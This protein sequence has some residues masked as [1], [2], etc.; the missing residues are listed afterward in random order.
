MKIVFNLADKDYNGF[1]S[2]NELKDV[3]TRPEDQHTDEF[4]ILLIRL[5][6]H[7]KDHHLNFEGM[8]TKITVHCISPGTFLKEK[9]THH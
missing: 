5:G 9:N 1:L 6:D 3:Q 4:V 2:V 8:Q 7:N